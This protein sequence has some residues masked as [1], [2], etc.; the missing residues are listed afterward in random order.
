MNEG[1]I[2]SSN[3]P[4]LHYSITSQPQVAMPFESAGLSLIDLSASWH[5]HV[6]A[7]RHT[8]QRSSLHCWHEK[9]SLHGYFLEPLRHPSGTYT[10]PFNPGTDTNDMVAP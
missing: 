3:I 7:L 9:Q 2:A 1:R 5:L 4:I 8:R 10:L 6:F